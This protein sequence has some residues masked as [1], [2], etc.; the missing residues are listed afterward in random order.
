MTNTLLYLLPA[1][2]MVAF[3]LHWITLVPVRSADERLPLCR[4]AY[5]GLS[6]QMVLYAWVLALEFGG[7][8]VVAAVGMTLSFIGDFFN[9]RFPRV[10]RR[11]EEPVVGGVIAF[12]I[13]HF[14]YIGAIVSLVPWSE[15]TQYGGFYPL[16]AVLLIAPAI[17]F[18]LRVYNPERPRALMWG[19]FLYGFVLCFMTALAL[20]AALLH[21]GTWW[22]VAV[23][24][25]VFLL[26]DAVMGETTIYGRHPVF[27]FQI[28]WGTYLLAQGLILGGLASSAG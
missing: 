7:A 8:S 16:L 15:L 3:V 10:K 2:V 18:R 4:G 1:A 13:A 9:L 27:E 14:F 12:F 19:A 23:G 26:S 21:G 17:I 28:P 11:M 20:T 22:L 25:L 6:S 5:L 24:A